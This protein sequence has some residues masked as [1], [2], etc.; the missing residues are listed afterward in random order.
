[1]LGTGDIAQR[2][3]EGPGL[4]AP[5]VGGAGRS[6][7]DLAVA[8]GWSVGGGSSPQAVCAC[9]WRGSEQGYFFG[10]FKKVGPASALEWGES[11][12]T[13]SVANKAEERWGA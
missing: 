7:A 1:M 8:T 13:V 10:S 6:A 2:G 5:S 4:P 11:W 12:A 9:V 3:Q